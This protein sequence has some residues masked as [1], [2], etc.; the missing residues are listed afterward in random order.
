MGQF[1]DIFKKRRVIIVVLIIGFIFRIAGVFNGLPAVYN[2]TEY[3]WAKVALHLGAERTIDPGLYIYPT[4]YPYLLFI[5]Y[6]L[7]FIVGWISGN[8]SDVY[9]FGINFLIHPSSFYV[10]PRLFNVI[11]CL[12]AIYL[13]YHYLNKDA[14]RR[15]AL[16]SAVMMTLSSYM[17]IYSNFA[18]ADMLLIFFSTLTFLSMYHLFEQ[19]SAKGL[20]FAGLFAGLAVAAKY[21]AGFLPFSLLI[22]VILL[23]RQKRIVLSKGLFLSISGVLTGFLV[24]N[25]LWLV[26]YDR[27]TEGFYLV[28]A[29]MVSAVSAEQ[30]DPY[31]WELGTLIK[32]EYVLGILFITATIHYFLD[33]SKKH[34]PA[35]IAILL[36]FLYVG[37]WSKKGVDY[38]FAIY[39]AWIIISG[40]FLDKLLTMDKI[41]KWSSKLLIAIVFVPSTLTVIHHNLLLLNQDTREQATAWIIEN[42]KKNQLLCYD[43]SHYD[44]GI[45]DVN[46]YAVYG[47]KA[48][49]L[50]DE[51]K[52]QLRDYAN[53]PR[54]VQMMPILVS[55]PSCTLE[56]ENPYES[57]VM[58]MRRRTIQE[59]MQMKVDY[60]ITNDWYY[61]Q[62]LK[63]NMREYPFGVQIGIREVRSFYKN[64]DRFF[65]PIK[66]FKPDWM[67]PGPEL[68]IYRL[69]NN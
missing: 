32:N 52:T 45:F 39:P 14:N 27:F 66:I 41:P 44:L 22:F 11:L 4:L 47:E 3:L 37:S 59:L 33:G 58:R 55:N 36:T 18:T 42:F 62:Y 51:I 5:L 50:P 46:R 38:L 13:V 67:T 49:D 48:V 16:L 19:Y 34:L 7:Y 68:R 53:H 61:Q 24:T 35:I 60:L 40:F 15:V 23:W 26:Y 30:G 29:Q 6:A 63:V 28:S 43:N 21:N 2:S 10:I 8:F 56:T 65:K 9:E 54:Q 1:T 69:S 20:Y 64:L 17:I 57:Q 31:L 25:P 12:V